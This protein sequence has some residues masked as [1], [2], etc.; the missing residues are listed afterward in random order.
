MLI[1]VMTQNIQYGAVKDGR[2]DGLVE[3]VRELGPDLLMLQEADDV[4]DPEQAEAAERDLGMRL[5]VAPTR[6][7]P[8]AVAWNPAR[9]ELVDVDTQYAMMLHHG[10][11]AP[12]FEVLGLHPP[13]GAPLVAISAH[14]TPYSARVAADE[15]SLLIARAYRY[16]GLGLI[17]GDINYLSPSDPEPDW[18]QV[19][20]YNRV[21]RCVRRTD[22]HEPWRGDRAVGLS[23]RD[24]E[25]TDV[26]AYVAALH[27][28]NALLAATGHAGL[29][30][31]DQQHVTP[32]LRPAIGEYR[33]VHADFSDHDGTLGV[34][35]VA[36]VDRGAFFQYT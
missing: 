22:E 20:P 18:S 2:W 5:V 21:A 30:R 25:M 19:K 28:D 7:L 13:L 33:L 31:V 10:Y 26:A 29:I 16:G 27:G 24:G 36:R 12:R 32:A 4:A 11:C 14:L 3:K 34:Y 9:L 1:T 23:L 17:A 6:N 15:I 35:D 8:T